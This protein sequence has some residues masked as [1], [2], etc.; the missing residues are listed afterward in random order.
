MEPKFKGLTLW[1][2]F[3]WAIAHADKRIE[4]RV[5]SPKT[6]DHATWVAIHAASATSRA[7]FDWACE[8]ITQK[9]TLV[10]PPLKQHTHGAI[11]A[12]ARIQK[13]VWES[14]LEAQQYNKDPW[15]MGPY[16]WVLHCVITL[17]VPLPC[18]GNR[19]LW[20]LSQQEQQHL[21]KTLETVEEF[22]CENI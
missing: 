3:A 16:G 19:K 15:W 1:Q 4:N 13:F 7:Y 9:R 12:V 20:N 10:I 2:P 18:A 22:T 17:P 8:R 21:L 14:D 6:W 11:V 5:W